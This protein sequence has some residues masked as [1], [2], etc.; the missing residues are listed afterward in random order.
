MATNYPNSLDNFTN[1][2]SASPI[3]SPSHSE[4]HANAN[5]AIEA[6]EGELGTNPKGAKATVKARLDDVDTAIATKAPIASPT[7][8]GTVT[9]PSGSAITGVP[10]LA[11]ANTFT[12]GVQQI[13]TASASTK[14]LIIKADASQSVNLLEFQ[15]S[16]GNPI[17]Y[18][19]SNG[20]LTA[21]AVVAST[22]YS[23]GFLTTGT[24]GYHNA[25][26]F[27]PSVI[28]IV[29]RG[30]TSQ[31]ANLTQWQNSAGAVQ[32]SVASN[33]DFTN[34]GIFTVY[35]RFGGASFTDAAALRV[36]GYSTAVPT[37]VIKA[38]ASQ[39]ANLQEW[40]DSAGTV[41]ASINSGGSLSLSR[42][43]YTSASLGVWASVNADPQGGSTGNALTVQTYNTTSKGI[44]I[45]GQASQTANLQEWQNNSGT[46]L[47]K[48]AADGQLS[49]G[50][51]TSNYLST[52][53]AYGN[54]TSRTAGTNYS[55]NI[56]VLTGATGYIGMVIRGQ[57]GQTANLQEWQNNSGSVITKV[58]SSGGIDTTVQLSARSALTAGTDNYLSASLSVIPLNAS[59]V[60]QVIRGFASQTANLQE[61]Q[62][63]SGTVLS[64]ITS[65]G[66]ARLYD[67]GIKGG[68]EGI[69]WVYFGND[70]TSTKNVVVRGFASQTANL[71]EW[72][73]SA[74]TA[75]TS[76]SPTGKL[77]IT[78]T[79]AS[80]ALFEVLG[81]G[82][83]QF[84]ISQNAGIS[85]N[86]GF[87][88]IGAAS[89]F[90]G[91]GGASNVV[92]YVG[93]ASG[94]TGDLQ[95]WT[96]FAGTTLAKI[97]SAGRLVVADD[98][99]VSSSQI[100]TSIASP[101]ITTTSTAN[102][103]GLT[104]S[105][106][107]ASTGSNVGM[108]FSA[109]GSLG[110]NGVAVPGAAVWFT[111]T[112]GFSQGYLSFLTRTGGAQ[113][114]P[115]AERMRVGETGTITI[116]GFTDSSIGLIIKGAASQTADLQ[117]WQNSAGTVLAKVNATGQFIAVGDNL[118][119]FQSIGTSSTLYNGFT[120]TTNTNAANYVM[121][122]A[123]ASETAFSVANSFYIYDGIAGVM[124]LRINPSGLVGI[125]A[126][127]TSQLQINNATAANVGLIV[128]GAASQSANL[129]E[130]Q[131]IAGTV[132]AS[133][134]SG[135]GGTFNALT[136]TSGNGTFTSPG[137][138]GF[139]TFGPSGGTSGVTLGISPYIATNT[140]LVVRGFASQTANLQEWQNSAFTMLGS[141][142]ANGQLYVYENA[143]SGT[144]NAL[145]INQGSG[146]R[147]MI[148]GSGG[149]NTNSTAT[150]GS[151][152]WNG[153][154]QL[155]TYSGATSR[156]G[157]LVRGIAS[158]TA[159]LQ[160]WQNNAGTVLT[161]I[162][163]TGKLTS[164]VDA[165]I[166]GMTIGLGGGNLSSNIAL[167][168]SALLSNTTGASNT[169]IG[170]AALYANTTGSSNIAIGLE[171]LNNNIVGNYNTAIGVQSLKSSN[172]STANYN[173]AIGLQSMFYNTSGG[174][175]TAIGPVSLLSNT[176]GNANIAIGY[177]ALYS[178]TSGYN[179]TAI[180]SQAGNSNVTGIQNVFI[181][182]NAG[183]NETGSNKL[184]IANSNTATP[185]IGGDFS[186]KTL[187]VAGSASIISQDASSSVLLVKAAA[188]QAGSI[189]QWQNSS[190]STIGEI[191]NQ[192]I[193]RNTYN[194]V[195][196]LQG[197]GGGSG[198]YLNDVTTTAF[199]ANPAHLVF[200]VQGFASQTADLQQWQNSA[201]TVLANIKS[202]GVI[203]IGGTPGTNV[204]AY[205]EESYTGNSGAN[206]GLRVRGTGSSSSNWK[207]RIIAGGDTVA[208]LMGE[209]NSQAW[210]GGHNAALNAWAPFYINP[211][212]T[213]DLY[214]GNTGVG[215]STP[216]VTIK[217][218]NG[219]VGI[220]TSS[221]TAKL[222]I[223]NTSASA[224]GVI[225]KGAASQTAD[226]IQWQ[227]SD[228]TVLSSISSS[229]NF[230]AKGLSVS[231]V[232]NTTN[233]GTFYNAAG[234]IV[235]NVDTS[236]NQ[237][238]I[239]GGLSGIANN[240]GSSWG[241]D[242]SA[243][244]GFITFQ[245][246]ALG[247]DSLAMRRTN[248]VASGDYTISTLGNMRLSTAI[249]KNFNFNNGNI[250][251]ATTAIGTNNKL[252]VNPYSTVDNLATVQINTNSVTNKGLVVQGI[253]SQTANLQEWQ[254]S[255]G[256][257]LAYVDCFGGLRGYIV[258]APAGAAPYIALGVLGDTN[259]VTILGGAA[260]NKGLV[261]RGAASQTANLQEWQSSTGTVLNA[262]NSYGSF[263]GGQFDINGN[264]TNVLYTGAIRN[265]F[266]GNA[267][268]SSD[269]DEPKLSLFGKTGQTS[270]F[271]DIKSIGGGSG[272]I[273]L[274]IT[275]DGSIK[276]GNSSTISVNTA[277][278]VDTVAISSFTT[279]EYTISIKQGSKVR[280][281]KVLVHTDGTSIDSTEYGIIEM[282]GGI[283]GILVTAS[284]SSTNSILQV[285]I[286][287][288]ATTNATIKLI[289]TML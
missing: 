141:L 72:Q 268:G 102:N 289:K 128:K 155:E 255:T 121:G 77:T 66:G 135:G 279:I 233:A 248:H 216:I 115:L 214:L 82:G 261:V 76:V 8:T 93:G 14:G 70:N 84:V 83:G 210:L 240:F 221:A 260:D 89:Y 153:I 45:V 198:L 94:Q 179:N 46:V 50:S 69:G 190:G 1:P 166:N 206:T 272:K 5:D 223:I 67:L 47:A 156:V 282:G 138:S 174:A 106:S 217:N 162:S 146:A 27:A 185:L 111:R 266:A 139:G 152:V 274:S 251:V 57:S 55:A 219:F 97:S 178:N 287:D 200:K 277:T 56:S 64:N 52:Y 202:D 40:Q 182:Y 25:T 87:Q 99:E 285:T 154:A 21:T 281:S 81:A 38:I 15:N 262:I 269:T 85:T 263:I 264:L 108:S 193:F 22:L 159:D 273:L 2:T 165:S 103:Y 194:Y 109:W 133:V 105:G 204:K 259:A 86:G 3:N 88:S 4:Q 228:G 148:F 35:G 116:A 24:L 23:G 189:I 61:W 265:L 188:S 12:G 54:I 140:A 192:G 92:L 117:Q 183:Y 120:V 199:N 29:V 123:G 157:L 19:N 212:G 270:N 151:G 63:S 112:G 278:T 195:Q 51:G 79:S 176:S 224:Q 170:A 284:V 167:G 207:G 131:N 158:Q 180:G 114:S 227:N 203:A 232:T 31:T 252:I 250:G 226:L 213:Q 246:G 134:S 127:P 257:V 187:T 32:A 16:I 126:V 177:A 258:Q 110:F 80:A 73:N 150:I 171:A 238:N 11:T 34:N 68:P 137:W 101:S 254:N 267:Y 58:G 249:G 256:S 36:N 149:L 48:V 26:T 62:N 6:I 184:Y 129:Q 209:Y 18:F 91:Y 10:Y 172:T 234:T 245:T 100:L 42:S 247:G 143:A 286:T 118:N 147:R 119:N 173:V 215:G 96:N 60:G 275:S 205:I 222:H 90:G 28:P 39:T 113:T 136:L 30:T 20:G 98:G 44:V 122:T 231:S 17:T 43:L 235:F 276:G 197:L 191:N 142:S 208:F 49:V 7:F 230:S 280:S 241:Y 243:N 145:D 53:D 33:G 164:A 75:L 253:A 13:T 65:F 201:G 124:R 283:T 225:V 218:S 144:G 59:V 168:G 107:N 237:V 161:N 41:A 244:A 239:G 288:A 181:G 236:L 104:I 211:D 271:I 186:A 125:N 37:A 242:S 130:W 163:S 196:N 169:S 160:Q 74:G 78:N 71:Q 220:G 175:N 229:G 9:I 132:V 95:R